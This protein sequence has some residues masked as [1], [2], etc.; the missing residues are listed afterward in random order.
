VSA[1]SH[2]VN[3]AGAVAARAKELL[4]EFGLRSVIAYT[5][6]HLIEVR[7]PS[8]WSKSSE[9]ETTVRELVDI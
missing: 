5:D 9:L 1:A 7:E 8:T 4:I 6:T 3:H 2:G